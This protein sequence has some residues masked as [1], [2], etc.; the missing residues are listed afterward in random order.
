[1][2]L[3][4]KKYLIIYKEYFNY[5]LCHNTHINLKDSKSLLSLKMDQDS[6]SME[7]ISCLSLINTADGTI[8][9]VIIMIKMDHLTI[10]HKKIMYLMMNILAQIIPLMKKINMKRSLVGLENIMRKKMKT[11]QITNFYKE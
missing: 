5:Q 9:M 11:P 10:H 2:F 8:S 1:M 4:Y 7:L 3:I 6:Q